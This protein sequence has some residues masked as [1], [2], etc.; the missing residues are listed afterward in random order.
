[1]KSITEISSSASRIKSARGIRLRAAPKKSKDS[2]YLDLFLL[3]KEKSKLQQEQS[4]LAKKQAQNQK[5]LDEVEA[6]I[7]SVTKTVG[8]YKGVLEREEVSA[9]KPKLPPNKKWQKMSLDY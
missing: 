7:E 8:E 1:M 3:N 2:S 4:N 9:P 5:R 6:N